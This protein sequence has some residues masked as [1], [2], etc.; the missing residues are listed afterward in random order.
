MSP[1]TM[2]STALTAAQL[3]AMNGEQIVKMGRELIAQLGDDPD[4]FHGNI[5]PGNIHLDD[6][7]KAVLGE[8]S[9]APVSERTPEQ[10]EYMAPE[11]FWQNDF[12]RSAD[13]YSI[14]LVMYAAYNGGCLPFTASPEPTDL[15]R[16]Q[17]LRTRMKGGEIPLPGNVSEAVGA[18]LRRELGYSADGRYLTADAM[19]HDL[20]ETDEA[21]PS[22][23]PDGEQAVDPQAA[24]AAAATGMTGVS[25]VAELAAIPKET[26]RPVEAAAGMS[27]SSILM[28]K[29]LHDLDETVSPSGGHE[30]S[31]ALKDIFAAP[32]TAPSAAD[33]KPE[34]QPEEKPAEAPKAEEKPAK[35]TKTE[36]KTAVPV[37]QK[38]GKKK[39]KAAPKTAETVTAPKD[40]ATATEA[41]QEKPTENRKPAEKPAAKEKSAPKAPKDAQPKADTPKS[42][43]KKQYTVQKDIDRR[44]EAAV[45]RKNRSGAIVAIGVGVLVIAGL[46]TVAAYSLGAFEKEEPM[47]IV[48][49]GPIVEATA[50]PTA[51]PTP[52]PAAPEYHFK[53]TAIDLDW[54]ELNNV[55][56][57]VLDSEDALQAAA[58]AAEDAGL[59]NVWLGARYLEADDA[60]N[61]EAGWYWLDDTQ[62]PETSAFWADGEPSATTG[63]RLMLRRAADGSWKFHAV[64]REQFEQGD[65]AALGC[66]TDGSG[67]AAI[68]T[69]TP[70]PT[71]EP[72]AAPEETEAPRSYTYYAPSVI[73]TAAP[74]AA[75]T[76]AP[77][78]TAVP[79]VAPTATPAAE[80]YTAA[81]S[82]E[83]WSTLKDAGT[84]FVTIASAEDFAAVTEFLS[85]YNEANADA[86]LENVWLGAQYQAADEEAGTEAGWYWTDGTALAAD[87]ANWATDEGGKTEG[88]LMLRY[89]DGAWKYYAV[90]ETEFGDYAN[91]GVISPNAE[92]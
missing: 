8:G 36:N 44:Q 3:A 59:E 87:D 57:A 4:A 50:E 10:I 84:S 38:S 33:E 29:E 73:V 32:E 19:L 31:E 12:S 65:F 66:I 90:T 1:S 24:A 30:M 14:A 35:K 45:K 80:K 28:E 79:T 92:E 21:L 18:I 46:I 16:A 49:A 43:P 78:A 77:T 15:E 6:D 20:G 26:V 82:V 72:T 25:V 54:D 23:A 52:T 67:M 34:E 17:A 71:P 5:W 81:A 69:P 64:T 27:A 75:P 86:K 61:G 70:E 53:A 76:T 2:L 88:C 22:E 51:E 58:A 48:T 42:A 85:A 63:G 40:E 83:Y 37:T 56:L 68:P 9:E 91:T 11:A 41:P 62:L 39:G 89:A 47:T 7:G 13:L 55:G 74:T 60:P